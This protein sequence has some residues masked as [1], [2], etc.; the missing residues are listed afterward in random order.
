MIRMMITWFKIVN[1][2]SV[3]YSSNLLFSII[4][5][6]WNYSN[7]KQEGQVVRVCKCLMV[8]LENYIKCLSEQNDS[9]E[10]IMNKW[11]NKPKLLNTL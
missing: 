9:E 2:E 7:E 3:H 10:L 5:Q 1:Y 4:E 6:I 8:E 11:V